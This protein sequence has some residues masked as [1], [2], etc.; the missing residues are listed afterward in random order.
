MTQDGTRDLPDYDVRH[1][2]LIYWR[3]AFTAFVSSPNQMFWEEAGIPPS[4][5]KAPDQLIRISRYMLAAI[6]SL[7]TGT[8]ESTVPL[9]TEGS[10]RSD[11]A[12]GTTNVDAEEQAF[13]QRFR[14]LLRSTFRQIE[15]A[16]GRSESNQ[17]YQWM[18]AAFI[19]SKQYIRAERLASLLASAAQRAE[20]HPID[21]PIR[22]MAAR[23]FLQELSASYGSQARAEF[24]QRGASGASTPIIKSNA[25][26]EGQAPLEDSDDSQKESSSFDRIKH[27][28]WTRRGKLVMEHARSWLSTEELTAVE[29]WIWEREALLFRGVPDVLARLRRKNS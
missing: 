5:V 20:E 27:I 14:E 7:Y 16:Y 6:P 12:S 22:G 17:L 15:Q 28:A 23:R 3:S 24:Q 18:Q 9:S 1:N 8:A 25:R 29:D 19:D 2:D 4:I 10:L 21:L 26:S 13:E 11:K